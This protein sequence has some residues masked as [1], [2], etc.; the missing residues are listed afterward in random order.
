MNQFVDTMQQEQAEAIDQFILEFFGS[1]DL[2]KKLAHKYVLESKPSELAIKDDCLR[3]T[4]EIRI[5]LKTPQEVAA[6]AIAS[7]ELHTL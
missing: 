4:Q 1:I 7:Q 2:F 5:R 3:M 6:E